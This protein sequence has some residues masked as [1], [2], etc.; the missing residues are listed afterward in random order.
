MGI[1][2]AGIPDWTNFLVTWRYSHIRPLFTN[3]SNSRPSTSTPESQA[4]TRLK[5]ALKELRDALLKTSEAKYLND[6]SDPNFHNLGSVNLTAS[7]LEDTIEAFIQKRE[8]CNRDPGRARKVKFIV[9]KWYRASY[10][11]LNAI[12]SVAQGA[13]SS[14]FNHVT[15]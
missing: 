10:P 6:I 15:N 9:Q 11:F 13:T 8:E 12:L 1:G 14:V 2:V 4:E 3:M 7:E 5:E